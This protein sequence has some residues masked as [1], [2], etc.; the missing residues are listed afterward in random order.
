M[1]I[2]KE[3]KIR[4][5]LKLNE[6]MSAHTSW[7][8]GGP[9]DQYFIP[10]DLADLQEFLAQ[11]DATE[12]VF[13]IGL[14]SNLLIRDGG[15]RGV[16]IAPLNALNELR[17]EESGEIYA[18]CGVTSSKM[19]K[20]CQKQGQHAA[21]FL[22]G[23]PGTIGGAL[24]MNAGAFGG[25]TWPLVT[26]VQMINREGKIFERSVNEFE[27]DYR[28]VK[29]PLDEWFVGAWFGGAN[30]TAQ[31]D[32]N[33]RSLLKK[34]NSSQPIGLPSCGSVF[35]N[36]SNGF[37]AQMIEAVGLGVRPINRCACQTNMPTS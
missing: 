16:V 26:R 32:S 22:A 30:Q 3:F 15:I 6:P 4:G 34:R 21:E 20:F 28:S 2:A 36:P 37:A 11:L 12:F 5:Q 23:I 14:G 18:Q 29:I 27:V 8:V 9:A 19:A 17:L 1:T 31:G 35:K 13:W 10:A 7:R 25:E 33:I 24:A